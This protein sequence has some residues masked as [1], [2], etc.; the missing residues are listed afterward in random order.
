[1]KHVASDTADRARDLRDAQALIKM[2]ASLGRLGA[3][4]VDLP[5]LELSW[6][7]EVRAIHEVPPGCQPTLDDVLNFYVPQDRRVLQEAFVAC[8]EQGKPYDLELRLV[9]AGGREVWVRTIAELQRREDGR[10]LRVHGACQD[11]SQQKAAAEQTRLLAERLTMTLESLTDAFFTVDREWR[12]TYLN[13]E[14]ERLLRRPKEE[15]LGRV[16]WDCFPEVVGTVFEQLYR[17]AMATGTKVEVDA[18]YPPLDAW[19]QMRAYPSNQGLA[20]SLSDVTEKI[21]AQDEVLRLNADLEDRVRARTAELEAANHDLEAFACSV[22]HDLRAPMTAIDAFAHVLEATEGPRLT[23]QGLG[24]VKRI[25]AAAN[26]LNAMTSSMLDLARLSQTSLKREPLDLEPLA[27]DIIA[28]LAQHEPARRVAFQAT[29]DL[30]VHADPTLIKQVL[31]NLLGN[32]WKF[33]GRTTEARIALAVERDARGEAVYVVKDNGAGFDM[34]HADQLFA[35][36]RR[37]H[38]QHEFEGT[39]IGLAT[40]Q[41]IIARHDGRI[42]ADGTVGGGASFRF[43]LG[44][45]Q[46]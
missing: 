38:S 34:R 44:G 29:G 21:L 24:H 40:V 45:Q 32:A 6:S 39:G 31:V 5:T 36:F 11:I 15:L 22:A 35:P 27:H 7:D 19:L 26:Q 25:R 16:G 17:R 1:M 23:P 9:A 13:A 3:W 42:W 14:A 20:V 4:C 46:G 37:L 41:R 18:P 2:A 8:V 12:F 33:T 43:T 28:T 30:C 10:P